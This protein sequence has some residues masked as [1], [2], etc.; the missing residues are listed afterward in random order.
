MPGGADRFLDH[1]NR[2]EYVQR[3]IDFK[4]K[5]S[6]AAQTEA[7]LRGFYSI[8]PHEL[9]AVFTP[10]QLM[11]VV[12]SSVIDVGDLRENTEY[13]GWNRQSSRVVQW[14]WEVVESFSQEQLHQLLRFA[15]GNAAA[16]VGGFANLRSGSSGNLGKLTI[17]RGDGRRALPTSH[18]CFNQLIIPEYRSLEELRGKLVTAIKE[19]ADTFGRA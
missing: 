3:M 8:I 7:F 10:E 4:M 5:V 12:G 14:F 19:G 11:L 13:V 16:P 2:A 15:T 6:T 9:V 18:T 17:H 1:S